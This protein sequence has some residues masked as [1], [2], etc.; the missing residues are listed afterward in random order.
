MNEKD[1]YT[2]HAYLLDDLKIFNKFCIENDID[3][4]LSS[5]SLL[6]AVRHDGFIP[7]DDDLD[8]MLTRNNY[9]KLL[10]KFYGFP[11]DKYELL[12]YKND[13]NIPIIYSHLIDKRA[14]FYE[15]PSGT[16]H[17]Y[18]H[19]DIYV[20]DY[21][22]NSLFSRSVIALGI[23]RILN[24]V[25]SFR[26]GHIHTDGKLSGLKL[27]MLKVI[28]FSMHNISDNTFVDMIIKLVSAEHDEGFMA[29]IASPYGFH[30]EMFPTKYYTELMLH[31]FED[32][33]IPISA[34][35]DEIL[36]QLYGEYMKL[37]PEEERFTKLKDYTFIELE[38][39]GSN[40]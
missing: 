25:Y 33:E 23:E 24:R 18:L 30:K 6:G 32:I 38:Q 20:C 35:F 5:G 36:K 11:N 7:W 37:P 40:I 17:D 10:E 21:I 14:K 39:L 28:A 16:K 31:S 4:F 19:L 2:M 26:K 12:N 34:H 13:P 9:E 8:I 15:T 1:I 22:K 29:P 27:A 3:F